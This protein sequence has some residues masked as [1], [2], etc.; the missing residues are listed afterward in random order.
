MSTLGRR[1][2][3]RGFNFHI[4]LLDSTAGTGSAVT[5]IVLQPLVANPLAGFSEC[6]G[7]EMTLETDDCIEGGRNGAVLKFPK[8]VRHGEITLRKG[9]TKN[10]ELFDWFAGFMLGN[11][12]RKDGVITLRDA[13]GRPQVVWRF[14]RGLPTKYAGPTLNALQSAVAIESISITHEGLSQMG[15]GGMLAGAIGD[16]ARAIGDLF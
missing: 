7:L 1:D 10:T 14:A 4:S 3:L 6:S 9:V 5:S 11:G 15:G 2:P 16:A 8:R 12:K 13:T